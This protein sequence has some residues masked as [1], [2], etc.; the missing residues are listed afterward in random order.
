[1]LQL[2]LTN[3]RERIIPTKKHRFITKNLKD[4]SV[5]LYVSTISIQ[6]KDDI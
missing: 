4:E 3:K 1:L 2:T 5:S 6:I